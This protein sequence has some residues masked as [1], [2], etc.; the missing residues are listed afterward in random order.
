M[1]APSSSRHNVKNHSEGPKLSA[2]TKQEESYRKLPN[3]ENEKR[4]RSQFQLQDTQ[5]IYLD[6]VSLCRAWP[7]EK[8]FMKPAK[9]QED[10]VQQNFLAAGGAVVMGLGSH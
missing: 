7:S 9:I 4:S 10:L 8:S 2:C 6:L 3:T 1:S 5:K